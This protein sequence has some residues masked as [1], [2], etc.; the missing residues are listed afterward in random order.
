MAITI[1]VLLKEGAESRGRSV[2]LHYETTEKNPPYVEGFIISNLKPSKSRCLPRP[3]QN[4]APFLPTALRGGSPLRDILY[5]FVKELDHAPSIPRGMKFTDGLGPVLID[6]NSGWGYSMAQE[7]QLKGRKLDFSG[8]ISQTILA[9]PP[10]HFTYMT[11]MIFKGITKND[12]VVKIVEYKF[13]LNIMKK[14][15]LRGGLELER[16]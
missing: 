5:E 14:P 2:R 9:Q 13:E 3:Q 7:D 16:Q 6:R 4:W 11:Q 1:K 8:V 10:K 12:K 15:D